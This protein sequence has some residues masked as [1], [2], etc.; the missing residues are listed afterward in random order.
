MNESF[1]TYAPIFLGLWSMEFLKGWGSVI[2]IYLSILLIILRIIKFYHYF[3]DR[4]E[5]KRI[6]KK[7]KN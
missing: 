4:R 5:Q 6:A 3:K 2:L 7:G 1:D